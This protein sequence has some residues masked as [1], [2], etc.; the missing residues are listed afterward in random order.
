MEKL[1]IEQNPYN[2]I[3]Y[4]NGEIKVSYNGIFQDLKKRPK[5]LKEARRK[6]NEIKRT[7]S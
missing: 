3:K 2:F 7:S 6:L 5:L 4:K 1:R